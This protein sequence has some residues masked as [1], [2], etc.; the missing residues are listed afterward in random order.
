MGWAIWNYMASRG[1]IKCHG[2]S[3]CRGEVGGGWTD[4]E[5]VTADRRPLTATLQPQMSNEQAAA[6][7]WIVDGPRP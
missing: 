4:S 5:L 2:C 6:G 1:K 7:V 3:N